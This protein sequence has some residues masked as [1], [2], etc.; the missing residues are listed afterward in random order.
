METASMVNKHNLSKDIK[1]VVVLLQNVNLFYTFLMP[2][3]D[4]PFS[5][6]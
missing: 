2:S 4:L 5:S 3:V 1:Q 6:M